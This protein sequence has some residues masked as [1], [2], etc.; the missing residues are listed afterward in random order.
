MLLK[1]R[2][3]LVVGITLN[4][5]VHFF[6]LGIPVLFDYTSNK[7]YTKT[8]VDTTLLIIYYQRHVSAV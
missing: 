4:F 8:S 5:Q 3:F 1:E 7:K 2:K 6:K